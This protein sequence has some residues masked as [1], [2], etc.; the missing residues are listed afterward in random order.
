M[1]AALASFPTLWKSN[2]ERASVLL[3]KTKNALMASASLAVSSLF[4]AGPA[5]A[6]DGAE[7]AASTGEI[8]VT[9]Q[10]RSERLQDVPLAITAVSSE[11]VTQSGIRTVAELKYATPGMDLNNSG[12]FIFLNIRGIGSKY[13]STG[14]EGPVAVYLDNTYIPRTN[15][16]NTLLDLVDPGSIE[17]LRGPQGTLYGR[18]ATGGVIRVNSANPTDKVEGRIAA[19]YGRFDHKQLDAML[20]VPVSD[21]FSLRFAGRRRKSDGFVTNYDGE[22]LGAVN[23][24]TARTRMKWTPSASLEIIGG[25]EWNRSKAHAIPAPLGRDDGTCYACTFVP[26]P[27]QSGGYYDTSVTSFPYY[28]RSFR[29]DLKIS[30]DLGDYALSSTTT[31]FNNYGSQNADLDGVKEDVARYNVLANGG[32]SFGQELQLT[33]DSDGPFSYVAAVNYLRDKGFIEFALEGS[34]FQF[35]EDAV[36]VFPGNRNTVLTKSYSALVEGVYKLSDNLKV[37]AGGRY[38]YDKRDF[39]ATNNA[40]FQLFGLPASFDDKDSFKAFTPRFVLAWDNGPTNVYYSYTRGF[41]AGGVSTP[42]TSPGRFVKPEKVFNHEVGVK[43]SALGGKLTAALSVFYYKNKGIQAQIVDINSGG[44]ITENAGSAE[45]YGA[46]LE[47]TARPVDGLNLGVSAG[48]L[49]AE[50]LSYENASASCFDP[51]GS[52]NPGSPGATLYACKLDLSGTTVPNAPKL[53]LAAN[54][55]YTF[56]I[57]EWTGALSGIVQYRSKSLF[58]PGAGGPLGYDQQKGYAV[59]N[60]SGYVSPPG[61]NVRVGFYVDNA[62]GEKYSSLRTTQTPWVL[63]DEP[64]PPRTYGARVEYK[65]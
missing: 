27:H 2:R 7:A 14:L 15:G 55:N 65:F 48:Y 36:G 39:A 56:P 12:G 60:F 37:T 34:A 50:Y 18:N 61:G 44:N 59:A 17:I 21:D 1:Q 64:A 52:S 49:H 22:D 9:A 38:T 53:T 8:V 31:Y 32:K 23:S 28:N 16:L 3:N 19:E 11:F 57:G 33:Y 58:W 5:L 45:G 51:T 42:A 30:L 13:V 46:E 24:Y 47:L 26:G 63:V 25:V 40:G 35:A 41:K 20:N 10:R 54:A 43:H 6:Q 4:V 29:S 62:F